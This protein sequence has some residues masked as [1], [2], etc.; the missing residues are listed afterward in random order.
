MIQFAHTQSIGCQ[1]L[2]PANSWTNTLKWGWWQGSWSTQRYHPGP[3]CSGHHWRWR[4][5]VVPG[6]GEDGEA[7]KSNSHY[8][9]K[10]FSWLAAVWVSHK[11]AQQDSFAL[12][13]LCTKYSFSILFTLLTYSGP[14]FTTIYLLVDLWGHISHRCFHDCPFLVPHFSRWMC[15]A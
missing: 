4:A 6:Q 2:L 11:G 14:M 12:T 7:G 9:P 3:W 5:A 1:V 8:L 15:L 13:L 10:L